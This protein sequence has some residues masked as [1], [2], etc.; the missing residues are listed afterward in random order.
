[1]SK[2]PWGDTN[3]G[4]NPYYYN[5]NYD[6]FPNAFISLWV[7]M[8]MNNWNVAANGPVEVMGI[9]YR[10]YFLVYVIMVAFVMI[11]V[12]V[13]AIIDALS[14]V[15]EESMNE[16]KGISDPL[17]TAIIERLSATKAPSGEPYNKHWELGDMPLEGE[18]RFDAALCHGLMADA[19]GG[20]DHEKS[21]LQQENDWLKKQNEQLKQQLDE[22]HSQMS[23]SWRPT[24]VTDTLRNPGCANET[25]PSR[26]CGM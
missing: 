15:R 2:I 26:L 9:H 12:L 1:M 6:G 16:L 18:V 20:Y 14:R 19:N 17:E 23:M 7:V 24:T 10:W 25:L 21:N 8:I 3:Y 22:L 4:G 13:G 11:N 5:L